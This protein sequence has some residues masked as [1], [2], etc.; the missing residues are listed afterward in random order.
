[1]FK[2][3][4]VISSRRCIYIAIKNIYRQV[5][6]NSNSLQNWSHITRF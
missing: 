1:M 3:S 4:D 2:N 5:I 6:D